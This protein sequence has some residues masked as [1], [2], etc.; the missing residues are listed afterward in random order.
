MPAEI[1]S[2]TKSAAPYRAWVIAAFLLVLASVLAGHMVKRGS[3]SWRA[4]DLI[5]PEG[6]EMGFHPPAQFSEVD[7]EPEQFGSTLA[8]EHRQSGGRRLRLTFWRLRADDASA[9]KI[10][11]IIIEASRS[12]LS[13]VLGPAPTKALGRLGS[14]DALEILDPSIPL[15]LRTLVW[16][17]GWAYAVSL[18]V[19]GGAI[20]PG[21]YGLFDMTCRSVRFQKS[22]P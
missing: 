6:W 1:Y 19:E 18:R 20:D 21:L 14:R 4:G 9:Y 17:S 22:R 11:R 12:W 2:T 8:Y 7:P 16:D 5:Q 13:L 15:V 3:G 10:A